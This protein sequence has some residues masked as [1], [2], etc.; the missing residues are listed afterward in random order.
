[1]PTFRGPRKSQFDTE[2]EKPAHLI[3]AWSQR[4]LSVKWLAATETLNKT[5]KKLSSAL[6]A[7]LA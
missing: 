1:M 4:L 5:S 7:F 2:P 6:A 3:W